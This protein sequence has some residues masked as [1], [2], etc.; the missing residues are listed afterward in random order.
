[1]RNGSPPLFTRCSSLI[2]H[3]Q[4]SPWPLRITRLLTLAAGALLI[5]GSLRPWAYAPFGG[6]RL[7][8]F[9][10]F[11]Y[12]GLTLVAGLLLLFHRR[13]GPWLLL[14]IAAGTAWAAL[15]IPPQLLAGAQ[16][17]SGTVESWFDPLNQLLARFRIPEIRLTDW[18]LPAARAVG[19]GVPMTLW[20]AA[21]TAAAAVGTAL[22]RP[23]GPPSPPRAC[24]ACAAPTPRDRRLR[25]CTACGTLVSP[26]PICRQCH[27]AA[28][29]GDRFCGECGVPLV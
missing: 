26:V 6:L 29:P 17:A 2:T 11:G 24:P 21:L 7:P 22:A 10:L 18:A 28:E 20:G 23:P 1:M 14:L 25:F 4:R 3:L 12:G 8:L 13:L 16:A 5:A 15:A 19:P 9:G 27:A